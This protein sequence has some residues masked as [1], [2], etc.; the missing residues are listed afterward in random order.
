[1]FQCICH[2][3]VRDRL[4]MDTVA[5]IFSNFLIPLYLLLSAHIHDRAMRHA[6]AAASEPS[7]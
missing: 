4:I 6:A 5:D 3:R 7:A 1:M 2:K